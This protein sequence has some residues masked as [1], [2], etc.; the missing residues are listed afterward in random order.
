[1]P[2]DP[3]TQSKYEQIVAQLANE[4][5]VSF[6]EKTPGKGRPFGSNALHVN[7]KIFCMVDRRSRFVVKLPHE[8]VQALLLDGTGAPFTMGKARWTKEWVVLVAGTEDQWLEFARLAL[9]FVR[10]SAVT[11]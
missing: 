9:D 2:Y 1:M 8:K 5:G 7:G 10:K 4:P 6:P 3:Q 11:P